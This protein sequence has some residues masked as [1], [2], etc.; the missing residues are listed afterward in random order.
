MG[1]TNNLACGERPRVVISKIEKLVRVCQRASPSTKI[2]VSGLITRSDRPDL[3]SHIKTINDVL[4]RNS[5]NKDFSFMD[6][7][8]IGFNHLKWDGLHLNYHGKIKLTRN[9]GGLIS[10]TFPFHN[11]HQKLHV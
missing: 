7:N 9:I 6:N 5:R 4:E 2:V 11:G 10:Q 8:N 1:G 3:N